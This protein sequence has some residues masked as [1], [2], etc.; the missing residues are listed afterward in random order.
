MFCCSNIATYG[1]RQ[2][3]TVSFCYIYHGSLASASFEDSANSELPRLDEQVLGPNQNL[4][5][6]E[7]TGLFCYLESS[8]RLPR[9]SFGESTEL[10]PILVDKLYNRISCH[11]E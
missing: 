4:P 6:R 8:Q 3:L 2:H 10:D 7:N 9:V 1:R 5:R 11:M